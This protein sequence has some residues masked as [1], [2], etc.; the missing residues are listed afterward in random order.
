MKK[1][2]VLLIFVLAAGCATNKHKAKEVET[3]MDKTQT[4]GEET[5]GVK[6]GDMVV[7]KKLELNEA[8]RR[9]Q[10]EVYELED[11][12]Y[13]NRKF[14]SKGLYGALKDCRREAVSTDLGGDGK[15]RW[16]EPVERV[17]DKEDD[18]NIGYDEKDK[19]VAVSQ[20]FLSDRI[21]RFK[22]YKSVLQKRQDEYEEKLSIC[23]AEVKAKKDKEK[24]KADE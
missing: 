13:G 20:E 23:D 16:T 2:G 22:K 4:L 3:K 18:W 8:L 11:R 5:V 17:T 7:Q 24:D 6:D 19:L 14:G 9:L 21:D 1:I 10:N 12:V 15:L